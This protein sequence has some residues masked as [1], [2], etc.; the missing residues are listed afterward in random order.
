MQP[1][2]P[3]PDRSIAERARFRVL[4]TAPVQICKAAKISPVSALIV[5]TRNDKFTDG[6][7]HLGI[8]QADCFNLAKGLFSCPVTALPFAETTSPESQSF[9]T[10]AAHDVTHLMDILSTRN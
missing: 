7:H 4:S 8:Y 2:K 3:R 10:G 9:R 5:F 6:K 1:D